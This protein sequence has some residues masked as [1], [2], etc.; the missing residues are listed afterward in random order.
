MYNSTRPLTSTPDGAGG[1]R[2]AS[3]VLPM[4]KIRYSLYRRLDGHVARVGD[5]RGTYR[6]L[7]TAFFWSIPRRL[8]VIPYRHFETTYLSHLQGSSSQ[9]FLTLE[10]G[11]DSLSRNVGKQLP[12]VTAELPRRTQF[13]STSWQKL[14]ISYAGF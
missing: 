1:Q 4:G 2:H 13:P 7:K 8:V 3:A 5:V 10:H 11:A 6:A 12:L 9:L 14:D